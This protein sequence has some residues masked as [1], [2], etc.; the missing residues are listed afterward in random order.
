M[1][2]IMYRDDDSGIR[3]SGL[4]G[5]INNK[6]K[7]GYINLFKKIKDIITLGNAKELSFLTYSVDYEIGLLE[8]CQNLFEKQR[9]VGCYYH[10]CKNLYNKAKKL[11]LMKTKIHEEIK[12]VLECFY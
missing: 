10:Y 12:I 9:G 1:L 8:T 5:L 11:G 2:V 3:Y 4:F 6:K 7:E